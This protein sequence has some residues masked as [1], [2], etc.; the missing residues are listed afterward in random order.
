MVNN[1]DVICIPGEEFWFI[2]FLH[3]ILGSSHTGTSLE[4]ELGR[5]VSLMSINDI[6]I[7]ENNEREK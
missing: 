2:S 7:D 5:Q 6:F 4:I 1:N 3:N